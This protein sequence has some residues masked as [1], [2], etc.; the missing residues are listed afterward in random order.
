MIE[1]RNR[2]AEAFLGIYDV[3]RQLREPETGC[4]WDIRQDHRSIRENMIEE[5]YEAIEAIDKGDDTE[6]CEELGDLLLHILFHS[7]IAEREDSFDMIDVMDGIREKLIRRHPHV[8]AGQEVS[9]HKEVLQNWEAIKKVEKAERKDV[10]HVSIL[11]GV[12]LSAPALL[13]AQRI[14]ERA[15]RIG[16]DWG[17]QG[18]VWDKIYEELD[19]LREP[20]QSKEQLEDELGDVLFSVTN[21]ARFLDVNAEMSLKSTIAKFKGRFAHV[22]RMIHEKGLENPT[23]EQM[24]EFWEEAK[25]W[26]RQA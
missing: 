20:G 25:K 16:F 12:P 21:L 23:L 22:E 10:D 14:Q 1:D 26:D 4:P 8:F 18:P 6:L 7:D 13:V 15:S 2:L 5:T 17:E 3:I 24:D 11:D 9:G 19:E